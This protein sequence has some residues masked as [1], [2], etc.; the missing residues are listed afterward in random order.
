MG[1]GPSTLGKGGLKSTCTRGQRVRRGRSQKRAQ[2]AAQRAQGAERAFS[3]E[4]Q[5]R[6][7]V[8]RYRVEGKHHGLPVE[9]IPALSH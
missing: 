1:G 5:G 6:G 4:A 9:T 3:K 8:W 2:G 7:L